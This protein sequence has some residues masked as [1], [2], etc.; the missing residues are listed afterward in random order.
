[1][2]DWIAKLDDFL[3]ISEREIL[4]HLGKVSHEAAL[5]KAEAEFEK[6]RALE[7]AQPSPVEEAF[8][9]A[10]QKAKQIEAGKRARK[11]P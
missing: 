6:F 1:M 2:R 10:V 3:R 7:D 9:E 11:K 8:K 4:N 5:A